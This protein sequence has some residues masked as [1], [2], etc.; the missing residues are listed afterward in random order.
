MNQ[1]FAVI[2]VGIHVLPIVIKRVLGSQYKPI[3]FGLDKLAHKPLATA[4]GIAVSRIN[5]IATRFGKSL[6]DLLGVLF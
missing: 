1:I 3:S 5:K 4:F 6:K 2:S